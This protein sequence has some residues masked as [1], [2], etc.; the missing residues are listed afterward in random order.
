M[1]GP[2]GEEQND[3]PPVKLPTIRFSLSRSGEP[4]EPPSVAATSQ[5]LTTQ[6]DAGSLLYLGLS[7]EPIPKLSSSIATFFIPPFG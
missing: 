7:N 1:S 2:R 5:S 3:S 4:E 6:N